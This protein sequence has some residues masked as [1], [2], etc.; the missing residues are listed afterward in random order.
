MRLKSSERAKT[1][2][3]WNKHTHTQDFVARNPPTGPMSCAIWSCSVISLALREAKKV[4]GWPVYNYTCQLVTVIWPLVK[5]KSH[6]SRDIWMVT[7]S[8]SQ[9]MLSRPTR[10]SNK[11]HRLSWLC[12]CGPAW[13]RLLT[14][15]NSPKQ[16]LKLYHSTKTRSI[17]F[18][19]KSC[20]N[21]RITWGS[22]HK[23]CMKK[24]ADQN[25]IEENWIEGHDIGV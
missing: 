14:G 15:G 18:L 7:G 4:Q 9:K 13:A 17:L 19:H 8:C 21:Q 5:L 25:W 20:P 12:S 22:L 11:Q 16:N 6:S 3:K 24:T 23:L 2:L 10:V 1:D